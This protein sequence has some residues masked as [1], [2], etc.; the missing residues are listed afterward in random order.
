[1]LESSFVLAR[2][3]DN[4]MSE[5]EHGR[6]P[7]T[8]TQRHAHPHDVTSSMPLICFLM[9][10]CPLF[11]I[12]VRLRHRS[13]VLHATRGSWPAAES[14]SSDGGL[15]LAHVRPMAYKASNCLTTSHQHQV[16]TDVLETGAP[17]PPWNDGP[18]KGRH[19][20]PEV[21]VETYLR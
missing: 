9:F 5:G 3:L 8:S 18:S 4:V 6:R 13:V 2:M 12:F 20:R 17:H 19:P 1:M 11:S 10:N 7:K 14:T 21:P 15:L 16:C